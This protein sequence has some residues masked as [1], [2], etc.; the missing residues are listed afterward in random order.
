MVLGEAFGSPL[1]TLTGGPVNKIRFVNASGGVGAFSCFHM[2][3]RDALGWY[4]EPFFFVR[5]CIFSVL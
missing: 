5:S 1:A 4:L 3:S 2:V